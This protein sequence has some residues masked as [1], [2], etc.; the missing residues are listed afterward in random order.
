[1]LLEIVR[2]I[3][4]LA[5]KQNQKQNV[6][7]FLLLDVVYIKGVLQKPAGQ[8]L[9]RNHVVD[10]SHVR[11]KLV[12]IKRVQTVAVVD[13]NL[14]GIIKGGKIVKKI[15]IVGLVVTVSLFMT[16]CGC[17]KKEEKKVETTNNESLNTNKGIIK[18]QIVDGIKFSNAILYMD[19]EGKSSFKVT[20]TNESGSSRQIE[21]FKIT[22][23]GK[24]DIDLME[25]YGYVGNDL[26]DKDSTEVMI[27]LD[28]D[29][30]KATEIK[31]EF[32]K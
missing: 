8:K 7:D 15:L 16:G 13:G 26:K 14:V 17:N 6:V 11:T 23:I 28:Q 22:F 27:S 12:G 2:L 1:M 32:E 9:V 30:K 10:T 3:L 29:M 19:G 21:G 31:Y 20:L 24:N 18:D 5:R 4:A 25:A